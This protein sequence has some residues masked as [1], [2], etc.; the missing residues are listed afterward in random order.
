MGKNKKVKNMGITTTLATYTMS[1]K[2]N[3][4]QITSASMVLAPVEQMTCP[5]GHTAMCPSGA[6]GECQENMFVWCPYNESPPAEAASWDCACQPTRMVEKDLEAGMSPW[7]ECS[8][9]CMC[10]GNEVEKILNKQK[11]TFWAPPSMPSYCNN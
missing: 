7:S 5:A 11:P 6:A 9:E 4:E 1:F 10:I 8:R 2:I 3:P